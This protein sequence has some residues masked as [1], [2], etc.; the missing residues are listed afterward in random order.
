MFS[1]DSDILLLVVVPTKGR[2]EC[3]SSLLRG[4]SASAAIAQTRPGAE[5]GEVRGI[6]SS[7]DASP[8]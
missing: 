4:L 1:E 2:L 8:C 6:D 3:V 5:T 7:V